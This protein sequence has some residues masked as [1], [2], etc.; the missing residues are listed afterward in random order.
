MSFSSNRRDA[1]DSTL[2]LKHRASHAR[3]CAV[4]VSEKYGVK[5][6]VVIDLV[7]QAC[8]VDLNSVG[9]ESEI[10]AAIEVLNALRLRG[11]E[12]HPGS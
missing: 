9:S 7:R 6:D 10:V 12:S 11:L 5:R 8:G 4:R 2:P 3:S 1:L